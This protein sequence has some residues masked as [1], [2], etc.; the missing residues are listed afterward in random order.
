VE[1]SVTE[2]KVEL[3]VDM[4]ALAGAA[5][6]FGTTTDDETVNMA[7]REV[8]VR[9]RRMAAFQQL[10]AVAA[11]GQFDS[12]LDKKKRRLSGG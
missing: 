3:S 1:E 8:M 9:V 4:D 7:L 2:K 5:E 10:R 6:F 11:T 12:L